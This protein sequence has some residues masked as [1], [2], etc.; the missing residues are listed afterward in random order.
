MTNLDCYFDFISPFTYL[1]F[2]QLKRFSYNAKINYKPVLLAGLL[3]H[4]GHK[5][6]AEITAR[7]QITYRHILWQARRDK[8]P[9]KM[10]P[11]YPFNP[12]KAIR[13]AIPVGCEASVINEILGLEEQI[14]TNQ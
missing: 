5:G 13:L 8:I 12:I 11:T 1:Q 2:A 6:P 10:P 7:R 3:K 4:W 14:V 9:F